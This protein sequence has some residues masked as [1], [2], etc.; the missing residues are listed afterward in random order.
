MNFEAWTVDLTRLSAT[1]ETGFFIEVEG[2]PKDPSAVSPG[3]FPK[4]LS[5]LEQ[6]RLLRYGMEALANAAKARDSEKRAAA[7]KP[8]YVPPANKPERPTLSLK[9]RDKEGV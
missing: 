9:R 2:S 5:G 1:H 8:A 6:V 4:H 7:K 3:P